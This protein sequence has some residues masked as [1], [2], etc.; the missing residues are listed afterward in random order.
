[1]PY[2]FVFGPQFLR[3]QFYSYPLHTVHKPY[4]QYK[5]SSIDC[6]VFNLL[7]SFRIPLV[8]SSIF[9]FMSAI[10]PVLLL[11]KTIKSDFTIPEHWRHKC[12]FLTLSK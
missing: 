11:Y 1:M 5:F 3:L 10:N 4:I 6:L 7:D 8:H 12:T 2:D 9:I